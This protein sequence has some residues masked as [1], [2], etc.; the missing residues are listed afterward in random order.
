M[1]IVRKKTLTENHLYSSTLMPS[2]HQQ[3]QAVLKKSSTLITPYSITET[4]LHKVRKLYA[5]ERM[6]WNTGGPKISSIIETEVKGPVDPIP[7]RIYHPNKEKVLPVLVYLHGGGFVVGSNDTH[8]RIMRELAFRSGCAVIGVEYSLAP[9]QKFPVALKE[10]LSVLSWLKNREFEK[11]SPAFQIDPER[12]VIGGDSAGASLSMG[13]ALNMKKYLSGLLLI[14][15]WFG[16][17]DSCSSRLFGGKEDGMGE[18]DRVFY[19]DSYLRSQKDLNDSRVD[20]L[21]ADLHGL[22]SACLIVADLDPLRDDS[23]ALESLL[24]KAEVSCEMHMYQG[25]MHGFLHYSLMLDDAV[26]A[27]EQGADFLRR[28][29]ITQS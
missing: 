1:K 15:G 13:V 27:L 26:T 6:F 14:Y 24:K 19:R 3:M 29:L 10:T 7:I 18:D 28:V 8:D 20:V 4:P 9:E 25:V 22:P 2:I 5:Q 16:L 11:I 12:V 21:R 23:L 17:R